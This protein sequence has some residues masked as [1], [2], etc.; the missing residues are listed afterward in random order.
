MELL[1]NLIWL[2]L[3]VPVIALCWRGPKSVQG[4][5]ELA[6]FKFYVLV[7]CL[8]ALLFPVISVSDDLSTV[9]VEF[10]ESGSNATKVKSAGSGSSSGSSGTYHFWSVAAVVFHSCPGPGSQ[11]CGETSKYAQS[12]PERVFTGRAGDRAP[13]LS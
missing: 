6:R 10:E 5:R 2:M 12:L 4:S 3:A 9:G 1:L 7:V 8:L 13:P 11:A